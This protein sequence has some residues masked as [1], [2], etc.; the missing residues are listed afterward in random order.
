M[1]STKY[2]VE[3]CGKKYN[4]HGQL[5]YEGVNS[6]NM[7]RKTTH[8]IQH[9]IKRQYIHY[10]FNVTDITCHICIPYIISYT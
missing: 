8:F 3:I 6:I 1:Q 5:K 7:R 9:V 2:S 10:R 4:I